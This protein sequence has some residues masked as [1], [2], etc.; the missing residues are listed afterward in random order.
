MKVHRFI[1]DFDLAPEQVII[2]DATLVHRMGRVLRLQIGE[3]ITL[4]DG[5]GYEAHGTI[6]SIDKKT[7]II[8]IDERSVSATESPTR[9]TLYLA[10]VKRDAFELAAQKITEVGVAEIVP[11]ITD[12]TIK[13]TLNLERLREIVREAAEQS[14]RGYVPAVHEPRSFE[15]A[16][17]EAKES[18]GEVRF[19]DT[20]EVEVPTDVETT[21][22]RSIFIG[23]EGG[24]TPEEQ[25]LAKRHGFAIVSLGPRILRAETA[26]IVASYLSLM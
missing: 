14:G 7:A 17:K 15:V 24:W 10:L 21:K 4:C 9:L 22:K 26:A 3:R 16:C 23:P 11:L 8:H 6:E 2:A 19:F 18:G 20:G 1:G 5:K 13:S 12:R 25:A